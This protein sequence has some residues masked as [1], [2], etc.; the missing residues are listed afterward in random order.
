MDD[1]RITFEKDD[2]FVIIKV[3]VGLRDVE[4]SVLPFQFNCGMEFSASLLRSH[5]ETRL[6][7]MIER[8]HGIAYEQGY[9][10]GRSK[11]RKL[12]SFGRSFYSAGVAW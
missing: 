6:G 9:K 2:C 12:T 5:L 8:A 3:D 10:D 7:D 4:K 11:R 1:L